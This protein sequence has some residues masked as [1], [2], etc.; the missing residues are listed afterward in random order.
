M[1]KTSL[2]LHKTRIGGKLFWQ[3]TIPKLG[4]GRER[5]TFKD[6]AEAQTFLDLSKV[7]RENFGNAALSLSESFRVQALECEAQLSPFGKTLR[8]ATKFYLAHLRQLETSLP[9][10]AVVAELIEMKRAA[11][12]SERYVKDLGL[13]LGRF[14]K[15]HGDRSAA[16]ITGKE[17]DAWLAGLAVA[18]GTRNTFRR[19]I[20]TLFSF[21]TKRG[22][23]P[24]NEAQGTERA[25]DVDKPPGI[26]TPAQCS[27]LLGAC[28]DD[29]LPYVAISLF[30]G[31]RAAE[32]EKLDWA[33]VDMESGHIEV[34]A[35]KSKTKRRRLV[36]ISENLAE[37]IRPVAALAGPVAPVGLRK[38][39]DAVKALAGLKAW[40]QNAMRHSFGSYRLAACADAA[41]VS[42]E[43]GNSPAMVFAHYRE[44][45]KPADAAKYWNIRPALAANVLEMTA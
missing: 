22:Y 9:V 33:E 37:W 14:A 23:C 4:G 11:H 44:L 15:T 17:L 32:L 6:R 21:C 10:S 30:A 35:A 29:V 38:R 36:P 41:R 31:L 40:P 43:M 19:D 24:N 16:S 42:L 8:D 27:A 45:V 20:R 7:Q 13:R 1:R 34:T 3:V 18:P 39:F 12:K 28:G 26:L 25:E 2:S 5:R